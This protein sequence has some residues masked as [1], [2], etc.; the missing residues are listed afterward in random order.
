MA[1]NSSPIMR[2]SMRM[3]VSRRYELTRSAAAR[4]RK[5]M[6]ATTAMAQTITTS[7]CQS[8]FWLIRTI[9]EEMDAG[10]RKHRNAERDDADVFLLSTFFGFSGCFLGG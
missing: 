9:T 10:A 2:V 8:G 6:A 3:P 7:C 5:E 1:V 4:M